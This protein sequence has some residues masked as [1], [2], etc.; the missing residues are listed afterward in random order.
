MAEWHVWTIT[1]QRH[2]RVKEF[3][4]SLPEVNEYFYPTVIKEYNT[5]SGKKTR[6]V[7]LFS[8]YIFIRYE[9]N[10]HLQEKIS[11]NNWIKDYVGVCSKKEMKNVLALSKKKYEDLVPTSE[12]QT[13]RSYKLIG[14]PFVGMTCTVVEIDDDKL[15]VSVELFGAGRLVKCSI[16]DID[17]ER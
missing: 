13:G 8:N 15:V 11:N 10:N 14:T 3:L 16:N 4:D 17:L 9:Y 12:V 5:K 1:Q 2:K 7:A 6:D